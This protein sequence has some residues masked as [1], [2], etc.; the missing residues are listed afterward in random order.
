M[1]KQRPQPGNRT[2]KLPRG[3]GWKMKPLKATEGADGSQEIEEV[4]ELVEEVKDMWK[5]LKR[6]GR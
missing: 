1:K 2:R 3:Y 5:I 4:K 6:K